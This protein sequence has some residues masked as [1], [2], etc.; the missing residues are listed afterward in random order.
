MA[1]RI[2]QHFTVN[3]LN[4]D[5]QSAYRKAHSTETA[6]LKVTSDVLEA[7]DEGQACILVLLDLSAAFDT[8]DHSILLRHLET[9][10]GVTGNALS[11]FSSYLSD[12]YQSV[13]IDGE[14]SR[15]QK[16]E[17]GVP[18]GS[19]LGPQLYSAYV[20]PLGDDIQHSGVANHLYADDTQLHRVFNPR[21]PGAQD[22]AAF[23]LMQVI[24]KT[25]S[26]MTCNKLKLNEEKTEVLTLTSKHKTP[27]WPVTLQLGTAMVESKPKVRDLGVTLDSN[28]TMEDHV[29]S[30]CR[31]AYAQIASI[32]HIRR[33]LTPEATKSLVH[34]LVTSRLDY[35]N[36]LLYGL[37]KVLLNKLQRVQNVGARLVTKTPRHQHITPV[38]KE[39]HW[40][41]V[42]KRIHFKILMHTFRSIHGDA[43]TYLQDQ[44]QL[45][46]PTRQLR[47]ANDTLLVPPKAKTVSYGERSFKYA[48]PQLWNNLPSHVRNVPNLNIFRKV[49]K[50]HLFSLVYC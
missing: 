10:F 15:P 17:Y 12:R 18:Q 6:L 42:D 46:R 30:V 16:L 37:P 9:N 44:I 41:P 48:A 14:L 20:K 39:L 47:S 45:Y 8:L 19:V 32:S 3:H 33:Y 2:N 23:T 26:W 50:T 25:R 38:L 49:L 27:I 43:P 4:C 24:D 36:S 13:I 21:T 29:N 22:A 40:L 28:M 31:S 1:S 7:L 11:W 5:R 34:A 35:C